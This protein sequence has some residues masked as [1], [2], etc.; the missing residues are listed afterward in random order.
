MTQQNPNSHG[1]LSEQFE[2]LV[3]ASLK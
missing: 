2:Q 1:E 3:Y